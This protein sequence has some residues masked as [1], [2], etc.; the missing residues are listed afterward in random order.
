MAL[1]EIRPG[2]LRDS[3][4]SEGSQLRHRRAAGNLPGWDIDRRGPWL[5]TRDLHKGAQTWP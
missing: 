1:R 4:T 5:L 3:G 2:L